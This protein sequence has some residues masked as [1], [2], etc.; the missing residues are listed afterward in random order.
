MSR[1][2]RRGFLTGAAA[3]PLIAQKKKQAVVPAP[4]NVV[5]ILAEDIGAWMCG[6][7]GN[8][9]IKTPNIDL[10][11]RLGMRFLGAYVTTPAGSP[12]RATLLTGR[13]PVQH[14]IHD[15]LTAKVI[16]DPP[17]GQA[18]ASPWF[19]E[20]VMLS[21]MLAARGYKCGFCG[22]WDMGNDA[23]PGHANGFTYTMADP[24]GPYRDP[25]MSRNGQPVQE[26][27][28]LTELITNAATGFLDRQTA[29]K[30]FL[31]TVSYPNAHEPYDGHPNEFTN[32]YA[33]ANF[34]A[35]GWRPKA[36]NA[37][38]GAEYLE[39]AVPN[40]RKV[41]ASVTAMDAQIKTL[42]D[43]LR[44]TK[45]WSNTLL[46]FTSVN[47]HLLGRHGLWGS[48]LASNPINMYEE[49][50]Q[51]PLL[52]SWPGKIPVQATR[53]DMIGAY[54]LLPTIAQICQA[55]PPAGK[56]LCGRSFFNHLLN[57][58]YPEGEGGW[59]ATVFGAYRNT[60]MAR[61]NRFKLIVRDGGEGAGEFYRN[62]Q[63]PRERRNEYDNQVVVT[64][65]DR[66]RAELDAWAGKYL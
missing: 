50:V 48:G 47:G 24:A 8:R 5:L 60:L 43:K 23:Q 64:V 36:D 40:I 52:A 58:P 37:L 51:V 10:L 44:A 27:G 20:E 26:T 33:G 55:Q 29:G 39:D 14:G 61:D 21:D 15:F 19:G 7:Y 38:R 28:Y 57:R 31:L 59:P 25:R 53:P 35:V 62:R 22:K 12:S 54:D 6:C 65:R 1:I 17:Q 66:L 9:E 34:E 30:P 41:A 13:T 49:V 16:E 4:P 18:A 32:L 46:V 56:G 45:L 2:S 42:F 3:A 11:A 63:D